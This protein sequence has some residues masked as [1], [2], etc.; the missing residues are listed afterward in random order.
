VAA[1]TAV[2]ERG[3]IR[4]QRVAAAVAAPVTPAPAPTAE[5]TASNA[6]DKDMVAAVETHRF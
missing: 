2:Y 3:E 1:L 4:I 6:K 5:P